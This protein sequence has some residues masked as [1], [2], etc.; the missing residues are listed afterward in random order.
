MLADLDPDAHRERMILLCLA[1][2]DARR[3]MRRQLADAEIAA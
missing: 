2:D 1:D 3:R